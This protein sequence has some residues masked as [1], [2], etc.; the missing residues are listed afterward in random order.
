[1]SKKTVA[2][3][4]AGSKKSLIALSKE[5]S[6]LKESKEAITQGRLVT[7][8]PYPR[9]FEAFNN[10][11]NS[12]DG[13]PTHTIAYIKTMG[14]EDLYDKNMNFMFQTERDFFECIHDLPGWSRRIPSMPD[15]AKSLKINCN[16]ENFNYDEEFD[17]DDFDD[18]FED[19]LNDNGE[20]DNATGDG[21]KKALGDKYVILVI[22]IWNTKICLKTTRFVDMSHGFAACLFNLTNYC[23][24]ILFKMINCNVIYEINGCVSTGKET[25]VYHVITE[26]GNHRAIKVYKTSILVFKD[27]D[28]YVTGE[29][30]FRHGYSKHNPRKMVNYG[31]KKK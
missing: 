16:S 29:F 14:G 10:V 1:M 26:D 20:W 27:R 23:F 18:Y 25:N 12:R 30:R 21:Q 17:F 9:N 6:R 13:D 2:M 7:Y 15:I 5:E 8:G 11:N 3:K 22:L 28:R 19:E 4:E 24:I 31:R